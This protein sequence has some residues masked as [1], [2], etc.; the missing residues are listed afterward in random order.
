MAL[1][2]AFLT[3]SIFLLL[4]AP[5]C[6]QPQLIENAEL[7]QERI[8]DIVRRASSASGLPV[9]RPLSVKLIGRTE[10]AK[11]LRDDATSTTQSEAWATREAGWKAIGVSSTVH[12][13]LGDR[14]A[15]LSRT[16]AG[17]YRP[18]TKTLYLVGE[19]ARSA[20]GGIHLNSLGTFGDEMTLAHEVIHALQHLH[21][22]ELFEPDQAVWQQQTDATLAL[23]AAKEGDASLWAAQSFGFLGHAKDPEEVL[24]LQRD[25][26]GPLSDVP[27]LVRQLT[28]F[29]YIYG[30]RFAYHEGKLDLALPPASTEQ[31]I[32]LER[33]GRQAFQ[34][35]DLSG[36]ARSLEIE[37]CRVLYQDTMGELILSLW[38]QSFDS[39][40]TP[41]ISEGWDGDRWVAAEC[42][43]GR[44]I[45]W[46]SSWDREQDAAEFANAVVKIAAKVVD[47]AGLKPPLAAQRQGRE[48]IVVSEGLGSKRDDLTGLARRARVTT[49]A[50]LAQHFAGN[51][52]YLLP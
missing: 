21:Y 35:M 20:K 8:Y 33:N 49:R 51:A 44:E 36:F 40:L 47:R 37:G 14:L 25:D 46:L 23:Q 18:E 38:L 29:P 2:P 9:T 31:V 52:A 19:H 17:L 1:M 42:E 30:Y 24:E 16:V 26:S 48:V 43:S 15:L 5:S 7:N 4:C 27:K 22:P 13:A 45:A 12:Q 32:H 39:T 11:I 50:E 10:L 34:A 3:I 41:T 28:T 6:T